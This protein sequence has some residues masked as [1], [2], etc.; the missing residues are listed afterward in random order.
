VSFTFLTVEEVLAIHAEQL[1]RFGGGQGIRDE[2]GLESALAQP[3]MT[4]DGELLHKDVFEMAAAYAFHLSQ[5]HPFLDGNKRT[6]LVAA[7]VFLDLNGFDLE[8]SDDL[9]DMMIAVAERRLDKPGI[10]GILRRLS[11]KH[12]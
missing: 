2:K 10:A 11:K 1:A 3:R 12:S 8:E 4:F 7:S 9:Y 6:G 5:N